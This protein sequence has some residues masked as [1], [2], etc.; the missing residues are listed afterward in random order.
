MAAIFSAWR[1]R[2]AERLVPEDSTLPPLI[3]VPGHSPSHE[4]KCLTVA[5]RLTSGP[6]SVSSFI[7]TVTPSPL[8]R[9]RSTPAQLASLW[10]TSNS[11]RA[12]LP[13]RGANPRSTLWTW[14]WPSNCSSLASHC[15]RWRA[16]SSYIAS[17]CASTNRCSSRQL[18]VSARTMSA[19]LALTRRCRWR[20]STRASRWPATMSRMMACPLWPITSLRTSV[21]WIFICT[22]AFCM[23]CTQLVCSATSTSRWRATARTTQTSA[24]GRQAARSSPRLMSFCS[25][26]QSCTSLLRPGTYFNCR[27]STSHT[28]NPCCSST[29]NTAIQY[30]PVDSSATV[31]TPSLSSH[32]ASSAK[33]SVIVPTSRT[34]ACPAASAKCC[35]TAT[36]WLDPPTSIPAALG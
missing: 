21:S 3:L 27:A 20:A 6:I 31:S 10:R 7:T 30:T 23:R 24:A 5:K 29:S 9:V 33:S 17:A 15:A 36:Q 2:L 25:H 19:S 32:R 11:W 8:I 26:W 13:A 35:G 4:Q 12:L 1:A 28:F 18:P 16:M 22:S 34:A 14:R